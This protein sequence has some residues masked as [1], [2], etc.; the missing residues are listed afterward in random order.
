MQFDT[1]PSLTTLHAFA[2][3]ARNGS[4]SETA[5]TL[6]VS[7]SQV[8][9]YFISLE[10][11]VGASL[12]DRSGQLLR[13]SDKGHQLAEYL[14]SGFQNI[15][16]GLNELSGHPEVEN[17]TISAPG[18][19]AYTFLLPR[20]P[21]FQKSVGLVNV[22]VR[23]HHYG[24]SLDKGNGQLLI[25][26]KTYD[27]LDTRSK[28]LFSS[29]LCL[30]ST[31]AAI[32]KYKQDGVLHIPLFIEGTKS[33][34][35]EWIRNSGFLEKHAGKL[36]EVRDNELISVILAGD[37]MALVERF[38]VADHIEQ[39]RLVLLKDVG[40]QKDYFVNAPHQVP[41]PKMLT[42]MNWLQDQFR[43]KLVD[44]LPLNQMDDLHRLQKK[45][46]MTN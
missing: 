6:N 40:D 16:Q 33:R 31:R 11:R 37:G 28:F 43:P 22:S 29:S 44:V 7:H 38:L 45:T 32:T 46:I 42:L 1:L 12:F 34:A 20:I 3:F 24:A 9:Q 21:D 2:I 36:T 30:V 4:V 25:S 5:Q 8:K 10:A 39:K 19:F 13:L 18:M 17:L 41:T 26:Q 35:N 15:A 14:V 27:P 23:P